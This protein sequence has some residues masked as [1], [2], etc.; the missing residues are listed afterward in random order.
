MPQSC[1]STAAESG[2]ATGSRNAG[3]SGTLDPTA[4]PAGQGPASDAAQI[5]APTNHSCFN[6]TIS[7]ISPE[8]LL[9]TS[10]CYFR[11][12]LETKKLWQRISHAPLNQYETS[13]FALIQTLA[14]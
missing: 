7:Q 8:G 12:K 13:S 5:H 3:P 11:R 6:P 10:R 2:A 14:A 4:M 9:R 1:G